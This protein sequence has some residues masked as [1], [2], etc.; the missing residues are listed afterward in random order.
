MIPIGAMLARIEEMRKQLEADQKSSEARIAELH[1]AVAEMLAG[2]E[3]QYKI[4]KN[5]QARLEKQIADLGA[6]IDKIG[7]AAFAGGASAVGPQVEAALKGA[8]DI[9][10]QNAKAFSNRVLMILGG[11]AVGAV[12]GISIFGWAVFAWVKDGVTGLREEKVALE[13]NIKK[14]EERGALALI[15]TC[16]EEGRLCVEIDPKAKPYYG[17]KDHSRVRMILKNY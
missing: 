15:G 8:S 4:S 9:L 3:D 12:L 13:A 7:P 1:G 16:G 5:Q 11:S 6:M 10:R 2:H 14:L 17:E